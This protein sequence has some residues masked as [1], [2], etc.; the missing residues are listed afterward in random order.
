[1]AA[2][3][4]AGLGAIKTAFDLAKGLKDIDDATRRNAAVIELQEKILAAQAA[5]SALVEQVGELEK[6]VAGFEAWEAQKQRY[7]LKDFGGGTFAYE[8]KAEETRG[9]PLHRI[10]PSCYEK[11]RRSILQF[12]AQNGFSQ[13]RYLCPACDNSFDFGFRRPPTPP[14]QP[15]PSWVRSR[16]L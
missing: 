12:G 5:Q 7:Q 14:D 6:Q 9:E 4:I 10:C 1:M 2:E 16:R 8:L 13:D 11:G 15:S 3:L